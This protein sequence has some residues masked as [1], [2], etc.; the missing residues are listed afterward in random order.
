VVCNH[1]LRWW[2]AT[3]GQPTAPGHQLSQRAGATVASCQ[4]RRAG[5]VRQRIWSLS[6]H[7]EEFEGPIGQLVRTSTPCTVT[8]HTA[9]QQSTHQAGDTRKSDLSGSRGSLHRQCKK[10]ACPSDLRA[11]RNV[12]RV[13]QQAGDISTQ[14][15]TCRHGTRG[16][17]IRKI[18]ARVALTQR[19][20]P[21][22]H[23]IASCTNTPC[24]GLLDH[25]AA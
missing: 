18:A 17:K 4:R 1:C 10:Q 24:A 2:R 16:S 9:K 19:K 13:H 20:V 22:A 7:M 11:R 12:L 23:H 8:P 25:A 15:V 5:H 3:L 6:H 14:I 21:G